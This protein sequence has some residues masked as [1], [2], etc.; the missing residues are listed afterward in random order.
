MKESEKE[1][2]RGRNEER[3]K[4]RNEERKGGREEGKENVHYLEV[5]QHLSHRA[6]KGLFLSTTEIA[7][8]N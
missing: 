1:R 2:K 3:K 7:T 5:Q 6:I 8:A 4:G